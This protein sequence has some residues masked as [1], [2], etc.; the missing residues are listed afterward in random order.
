MGIALGTEA[1]KVEGDSRIS[2]KDPIVTNIMWRQI[3]CMAIYQIVVM[4]IFMYFGE[5]MFFKDSFNLVTA[6]LRNEATDEPLD[7]LTLDTIQFYTFILMNLFNQFN[8]RIVVDDTYNVFSGLWRNYFF[9]LVVGF[10]FFLTWLMVDIGATTIGSSLI[11]TANLTPMMHLVVWCVGGSTLIW[12]AILKK[13]PAEKF[14]KIALKISLEEEK[15]DDPLNQLI[16]KA[17]ELHSKAR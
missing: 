13:I 11:G 17:S 7:P 3:I 2:R 1:P 10:E 14:D 12:G 6:P 15:P 5:M 4:M 16:G 9:I 8:C